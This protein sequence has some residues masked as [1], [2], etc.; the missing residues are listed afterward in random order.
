MTQFMLDCMGIL[1]F[2]VNQPRHVPVLFVDGRQSSFASD[3]TTLIPSHIPVIQLQQSDIDPSATLPD[4]AIVLPDASGVPQVYWFLDDHEITITPSVAQPAPTVVGNVG[5]AN[6]EPSGS[7]NSDFGWMAR[8]SAIM[9]TAALLLPNPGLSALLDLTFGNLTNSGC[10]PTPAG[11]AHKFVHYSFQQLGHPSPHPVD[12]GALANG[13][14]VDLGNLNYI[15][16]NGTS[17]RGA[18]HPIKVIGTGG[19]SMI[20]IWNSPPSHIFHEMNVKADSA[21]SYH[22]ELFY[23]LL[24]NPPNP[25]LVPFN[26]EPSPLTHNVSCPPA[27][28]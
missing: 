16:L 22:F 6:L 5:H 8:L 18:E 1:F 12:R 23:R 2:D 20:T 15:I 19:N 14:Q 24:Q 26:I 10:L 9:G 11:S 4:S 7:D 28:I 3:G 21:F 17:P 25:P 27:Q 13:V